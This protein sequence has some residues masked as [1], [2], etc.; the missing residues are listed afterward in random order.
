MLEAPKFH[1]IEYNTFSWEKKFMI[2][3]KNRVNLSPIT[4]SETKGQRIFVELEKVSSLSSLLSSHAMK[5][6][7][8]EALNTGM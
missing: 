2:S 4:E 5:I 1:I 6:N 8:L 7:P 3:I